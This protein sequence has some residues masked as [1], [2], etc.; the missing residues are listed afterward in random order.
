MKKY[1][2]A[3]GVMRACYDGFIKTGAKAYREIFALLE[4]VPA[5][6]V[7]EVR[8]G[9][10]KEQEADMDTIYECSV[11]G[12]PFVTLEGTPADNLWHYCPN[13][14]TKMDKEENE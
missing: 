3:E 10:W 8:H 4:A 2:D 7:Q 12:E 1:I 5:E 9:R 6:D 13:C 14:G 11:C